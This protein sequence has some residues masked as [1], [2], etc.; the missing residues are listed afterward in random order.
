MS[1]TKKFQEIIGEYKIE[2]PIIQRDYAQGRQG[3]NI[4]QIRNKFLDAIFDKLKNDKNLHLDFVYGSQENGKFIPL[5]GQQRLTTLFLLHWYFGTKEKQDISNLKNFTYETRASSREFCQG[6]VETEI[7]FSKEQSLS[8]QIKDS[9]WFLTFWEK[10]PTVKSM[11]TMINAIHKKFKTI[12]NGFESLDNIS[13]EFLQMEHFG[14]TDDLYIKMNARGKALTDFENWKAKFQQHIEKKEFENN[15]AKLE[16]KFSHKIDTVWLD[17]FWK[18]D[19]TV[20]DKFMHF[21]SRI[22]MQAICLYGKDKENRAKIIQKLFNNPNDTQPDH[23][24]NQASFDYLKHC[25]ELYSNK[26]NGYYDEL[27]IDIE[28]WTKDTKYHEQLFKSSF[29]DTTYHEQ[30]LFFAQTQYLLKLKKENKEFNKE[31][32]Q[33]WLRVIRNIVSNVTVDSAETFIRAIS[34]VQELANGCE[35]IYDYLDNEPKIKSNVA[36]EQV[37]QEILKA[38]LIL[39]DDDNKK[40]IFDTE[41][42]YFCMGD[43]KFPLYC[44]NFDKKD[45]DSFNRDKLSKIQK[46]VQTYLNQDSVSNEFR[47]GL[48]T[49]FDGEYY[50]HFW[51]SPTTKIEGGFSF[52]LIK[53]IEALRHFITSQSKWVDDDGKDYLKELINQLINKDLSQLLEDFEPAASMENWKKLIIQYPEFLDR[54]GANCI[55]VQWHNG[56]HGYIMENQKCTERYGEPT[57]HKINKQTLKKIQAT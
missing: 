41:D 27:K 17:L 19:K 31:A 12:E 39:N 20:D 15:V 32:F 54:C 43:I 51:K 6:L 29:E 48:F 53:N 26:D 38:K 10:D 44:I 21:I 11:L 13:F 52:R 42:T 33:N 30:V 47:R 57:Y 35:N 14:L 23:F 49:I 34:L 18:A 24:S 8:E 45:L 50:H 56:V 9:A 1:N 3:K 7:D 2:I 46:V 36:K 37:E 28:L 16:E 22:A 25:F 4:E 40:V 55:T 5:D